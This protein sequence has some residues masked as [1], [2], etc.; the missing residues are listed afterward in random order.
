MNLSSVAS[1]VRITA[2]VLIFVVAGFWVG[3][4]VV[5]SAPAPSLASAEQRELVAE[6]PDFTLQTLDG[7]QQSVTEYRDDAL[8]INF[9]ATW[10]P[11][12]IR[13][14]PL[15]QTLHDERRG[16]GFQVLGVAVDRL[17]D[18]VAFITENGITYPILTGQQS[19]MDAAE[20]FGPEFVGL[21]FS[22]LVAPGGRVIGLRSGELDRDELRELMDI[23]DGVVAGE[24]SISAAR[25]QL[26]SG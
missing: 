22:V 16:S 6:L 26:A 25:A 8:L 9:W 19:G 20:A 18:V 13:E 4:R 14:M 7:G 3:Q 10:C 17:P 2:F 15:L 5:P 24:M 12:C 1:A 23:L 11:P 21:P